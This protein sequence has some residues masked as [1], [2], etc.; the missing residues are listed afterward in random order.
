MTVTGSARF[1]RRN[2]APPPNNSEKSKKGKSCYPVLLSLCLFLAI[3]CTCLLSALV[4]IGKHLYQNKNDTLSEDVTVINSKKQSFI[5][6]LPNDTI[7]FHYD[8]TIIPN[9]DRGDFKGKVN[10]SLII[11]RTRRNILVHSKD[12]SIDKVDLYFNNNS[13]VIEVQNVEEIATS[14]LISVIPKDELYPGFY[15]LNLE[16]SGNLLNKTKGL[17]RSQYKKPDTNERRYVTRINLITIRILDFEKK[18]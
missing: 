11:K 14:E 3:L 18:K 5:A 2:V 6:R 7:P 10:I 4:L 16:F 13:K 15:Y 8:L 1:H 17:Y 12:L 9:T